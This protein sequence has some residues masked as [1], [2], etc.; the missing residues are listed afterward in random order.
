MKHKYCVIRKV[1]YRIPGT[2]RIV[3][4]NVLS[5]NN[6]V[7]L[8]LIPKSQTDEAHL[9]V[10][11]EENAMERVF[12]SC[13]SSM[14]ELGSTEIKSVGESL[15]ALGSKLLSDEITRAFEKEFDDL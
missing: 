13:G 8:L 15:K 2:D 7:A 1:P 10:F 5:Q 11:A 4:A 3:W 6:G 9:I 12:E 14:L